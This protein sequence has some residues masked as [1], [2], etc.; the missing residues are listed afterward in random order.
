MI[1]ANG[2]QE[3]ASDSDDEEG[4]ADV[5]MDDEWHGISESD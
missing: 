4:G 5:E 2:H 1:L 3:G